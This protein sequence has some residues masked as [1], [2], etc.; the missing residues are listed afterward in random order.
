MSVDL[1]A[2]L[3]EIAGQYITK[4]NPVYIEG[5]LK[6][7]QWE[8]DGVKQT[9]TKVVAESLQL[10]SSRGDSVQ[11]KGVTQPRSTKVASQDDD[12]DIPF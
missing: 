12:N 6:L 7:D 1:F 2:R 3:A 10:L 9:K 4:G 8:K 5:R 11:S